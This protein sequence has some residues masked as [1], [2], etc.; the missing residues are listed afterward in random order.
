[1]SHMDIKGRILQ[2]LRPRRDGVLLRSDVNDFG[3]RSQVSLLWLVVGKTG[4]WR[5]SC[6]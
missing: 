1:M 2:S 4:L 5:S 6:G 3:S